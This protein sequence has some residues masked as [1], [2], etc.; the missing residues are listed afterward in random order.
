MIEEVTMYRAVCD[1]CG[2]KCGE[3]DEISAWDDAD[4]AV[5]IALEQDWQNIN[6]RLLCPD[7][8]EIDEETDEYVE[9]PKEL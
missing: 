1:R 7:C 2:Y 5:D 4:Y 6:G 8:Y 3:D 9:K